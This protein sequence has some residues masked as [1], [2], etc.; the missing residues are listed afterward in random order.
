MADALVLVT[1]PGC[2]PVVCG[3]AVRGM[4]ERDVPYYV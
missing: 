4:H 3:H 2:F 1:G